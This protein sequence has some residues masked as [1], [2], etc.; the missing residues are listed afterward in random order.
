MMNAEAEADD[1]LKPGPSHEPV[2]GPDL[3]ESNPNDHYFRNPDWY[4]FDSDSD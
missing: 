2:Q 3:G 1:T 4:D